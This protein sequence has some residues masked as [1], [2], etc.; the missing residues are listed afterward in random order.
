MFAARAVFAAGQRRAFSAS[1]RNVSRSSL[2][3]LFSHSLPSKQ[4]NLRHLV[5]LD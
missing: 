1:A 3:S 5:Y 2:V 4:R